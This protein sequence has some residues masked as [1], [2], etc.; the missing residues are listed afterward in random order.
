MTKGE[1]LEFLTDLSDY[2]NVYVRISYDGTTA[3]RIIDDLELVWSS[4]P[5]IRKTLEVSEDQY[6]AGTVNVGDALTFSFT[7]T[8]QNLTDD[9]DITTTIGEVSPQTISKGD[10]A[11]EVTWTYTPTVAGDFSGVITVTDAEDNL[12]Q[13][14]NVSGTAKAV[15]VPLALPFVETFDTNDG[16]GG[17]DNKWSGTIASSHLNFDNVGWEVIN[18]SGANQCGKFGTGSAKGSATTPTLLFEDG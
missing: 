9:I 12:T 6:E 11:T 17:N 2:E 7:V 4:T 1:W 13:T 8:Q 16:T 10:G 5:I 3:K 18:G 15:P 14:I